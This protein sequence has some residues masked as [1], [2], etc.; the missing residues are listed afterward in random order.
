MSPRSDTQFHTHAPRPRLSRPIEAIAWFVALGAAFGA[1]FMLIAPDGQHLGWSVAML[2]GTPFSD[3]ALP[4]LVLGLVVGGTQ[5]AAALAV[6]LRHPRSLHLA[7]FAAVTLIIWLVAQIALIGFF[8]LQLLMLAIGLVE[9]T[10]ATLSLA[11]REPAAAPDNLA[12]AQ[13]FLAH[14]KVAIVGLSRDPRSFSRQIAN[15]MTSHGIDVV[16]VNRLGSDPP[17]TVATLADVPDLYRRPVF[18]IAPASEAL[19]IVDEA[20]A[21]GVRHLWFHQG[22]GPASSTPAAVQRARHAG[23]RVID[24]LCPFMVLEPNHWLHG[25]HR[26]LRLHS[27][28]HPAHSALGPIR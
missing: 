5:L 14:G 4:G 22:A 27:A 1:V 6:R 9:L 8:G 3:F 13:D 11:S 19:T 26:G 25:L 15:A 21:A 17:F 7:A 28:S 12:H 10:L 24:D 16:G 2:A 18:V 20:I 23:I